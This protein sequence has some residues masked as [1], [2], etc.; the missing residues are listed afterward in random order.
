MSVMD[1]EKVNLELIEALLEW[2]VDGKHAYPPGNTPFSGPV[3]H[4]WNT[5]SFTSYKSALEWVA[6]MSS[7]QAILSVIFSSHLLC[8]A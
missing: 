1:F 5:W 2:I 3:M 7:L 6:S 4:I 8:I